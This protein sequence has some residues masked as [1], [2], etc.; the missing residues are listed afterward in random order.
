MGILVKTATNGYSVVMR[1]QPLS[2]PSRIP[3]YEFKFEPPAGVHDS[4]LARIEEQARELVT[5]IAIVRAR[6]TKQANPLPS[7]QAN[8]LR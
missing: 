7:R 4:D 5:M 6:G 2:P 8:G 3:Q 1:Q